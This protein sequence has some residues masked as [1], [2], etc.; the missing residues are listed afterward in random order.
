[1]P[2]IMMKHRIASYDSFDNFGLRPPA[3]IG[4]DHDGWVSKTSRYPIKWV[5]MIDSVSKIVCAR[6]HARWLWFPSK[7]YEKIRLCSMISRLT[8]V[9]SRSFFSSSQMASQNP[10][11]KQFVEVCE[12]WTNQNQIF[13]YF[14]WCVS[15]VFFRM[16]LQTTKWSSSQNP[17]ALSA[18]V[19]KVSSAT[20]FP[21]LR[22][23]LLSKL[24]SKKMGLAWMTLSFQIR[25]ATGWWFYSTIPTWEDRSTHRSQCLCQWVQPNA[26]DAKHRYSFYV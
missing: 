24:N 8:S 16:P 5:C 25:R 20:T 14:F 19:S 11:V 15:C 26:D 10:S 12:I 2:E 1:M 23:M 22:P 13:N 17:P 4:I 9:F 7:V 21:M 18:C 6:C 3:N